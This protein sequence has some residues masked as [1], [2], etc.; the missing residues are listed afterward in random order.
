MNILLAVSGS[1]S[2]YKTIDLA[3]GLVKL[4]HE[5]K[6][7]LTAGAMEFI[8][9][10]LFTYLGVKDVYTA[11]EDFQHKNVLHVDLARW[12]DILVIAPTS[13][14]TLSRLA[15]GEAS[16]LL[17]SI[18]LAIEPHKPIALFPAM[19]TNMLHHP[20]TKQNMDDLKKLKTL[21]Q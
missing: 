18:F 6:V 12:C 9:P 10:K 11:Q 15:R 8:V 16:D 20:F 1:I 3:R 14:N 13:A 2:A 5:V 4:G 7:V 21:S 19:N 17:T